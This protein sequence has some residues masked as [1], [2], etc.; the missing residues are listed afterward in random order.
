[1]NG[2]VRIRQAEKARL[3][4]REMVN[5]LVPGVEFASFR[6]LQHPAMKRT[7]K[8][9]RSGLLFEYSLRATGSVVGATICQA[10]DFASQTSPAQ[11]LEERLPE[12][13]REGRF[14]GFLFVPRNNGD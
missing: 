2:N 13:G 6:Q 12:K 9:M 5:E 11:F 14:K 4:R 7:T 3:G 10:E 1:M 8:W